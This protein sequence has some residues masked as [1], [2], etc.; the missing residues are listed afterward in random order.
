MAFY[1]ITA[2]SC[3]AGVL[4]E[5]WEL[6]DESVEKLARRAVRE[7]VRSAGVFPVHRPYALVYRGKVAALTNRAASARRL[8]ERAIAEARLRAMPHAEGLAELAIARSLPAGAP[9]RQARLTQARVRFTATKARYDLKCAEAEM[10][11]S[12][13]G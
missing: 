10:G 11:G 9:E 5:L 7:V 3:V 4:L 6:G 13:S 12:S 8:W 1:C 2:Y